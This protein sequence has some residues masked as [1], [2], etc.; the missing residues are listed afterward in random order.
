[1]KIKGIKLV[2]TKNSA[3]GDNLGKMNVMITLIDSSIHWVTYPKWTG[4]QMSTS[5]GSY[6]GGD[7]EPVYFAVGDAMYQ[8]ICNKADSVLESFSASQNPDVLALALVYDQVKKD[9]RDN[10]DQIEFAARQAKRRAART[11]ALAASTE[12]NGDA[13]TE[14]GLI[15]TAEELE[16]IASEAELADAPAPVAAPTA[17]APKAAAAATAA[18]VVE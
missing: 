9:E 8:G 12:V 6:I 3:N 16:L 11:A 18:D 1:M 4:A 2:K 7:F 17:K 5:L 13:V 14:E 15:L 10:I